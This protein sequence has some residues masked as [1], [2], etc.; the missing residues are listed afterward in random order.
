MIEKESLSFPHIVLQL[1]MITK[2][3]RKLF[4][5]E[6]ISITESGGP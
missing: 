4:Q 3:V 2:R 5:F 1:F 6:K